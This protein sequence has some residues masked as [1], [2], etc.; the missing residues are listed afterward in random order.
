MISIVFGIGH[1]YLLCHSESDLK[2]LVLCKLEVLKDFPRFSAVRNIHLTER[3]VMK[4]PSKAV[5][6][7]IDIY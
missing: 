2:W 6:I 3:C 5:D 4:V 7:N 1:S